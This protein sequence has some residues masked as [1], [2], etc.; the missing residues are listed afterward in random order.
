MHIK[1]ST[2]Y[3]LISTHYGNQVAKR[4]QV[5]LIN[6]IDEGLL[7]L[8]E[9]GGATV[10]SMKAFCL[11]PLL[12]GD[13]DLL[14]HSRLVTQCDPY[15]IILAMEYRSVAN[16]YLSDKVGTGH[17][18]RISPLFEVNDMLIAD[19]VQNYKDFIT[20]HRGTH[21]RSDELDAYFN[22]WLN[23]LDVGRCEFDDL[24]GMIDSYT[25]LKG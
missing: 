24:C 8:Q 20:Y 2:E 11:H 3:R 22:D 10:E 4:S 15:V 12:Q 25:Q 21:P 14:A 5:P 6:H 13:S 9:L 1:Q 17:M 18:I 7:I 19:K 16:E 23:V